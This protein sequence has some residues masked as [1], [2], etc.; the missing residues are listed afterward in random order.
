[1]KHILTIILL[2]LAIASYSQGI[3]TREITK[4]PHFSRVVLASGINLTIT[5][6]DKPKVTIKGERS[7]ISQV[8]C[9]VDDGCMSIFTNKF[10]YKKTKRIDIFLEVDSALT[11]IYGTSGNK[12]RCEMPLPCDS[13]VLTARYGCDF[14]VNVNA[15]YLK[16]KAITG[17]DIRLVGNADRVDIFAENASTI[18]AFKMSSRR[19]FVAAT[20]SSDVDISVSDIINISST[21][22]CIVRYKGNPPTAQINA[23]GDSKVYAVEDDAI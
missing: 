19:N 8:V 15:G 10:R 12:V 21:D 13:L 5:K 17:S 18:R 22:N 1:M 16:A 7:V 23:I 9:Q 6:G 14:F 20:V 2:L 4:L 3:S 11:E